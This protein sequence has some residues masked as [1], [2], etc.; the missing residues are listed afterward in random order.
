VNPR[1]RIYAAVGVAGV[2]VLGGGFLLLGRGGSQSSAAVH[3]IKPLHPVSQAAKRAA[4]MQTHKAK[5]AIKHARASVALAP[6]KVAKTEAA[7]DSMP[8]TLST[9]LRRNAV[10]VV[11]LVVPRATVDDLAYQEAKAGAREAGAGF[12]RISSGNADDVQALSTLIDSDADAGDRLLDAPA[13]LVFRR[14]QELYVRFN[15]Y[16]D[17]DTVAQAVENA[18]PVVHVQSSSG[19]LASSWVKTANEICT[20]LGMELSTKSLPTNRRD[21]V[22][23]AQEFVDTIRQGVDKI[24]HVKPPAGKKARVD[25]MLG[26]YDRLFAD[27]NAAL[28]AVR[29]GDV[30]TFQRLAAKVQREGAQGDAI[31]AELGATACSG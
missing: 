3:Q 21:L 26:A 25:A 27:A 31:A 4:R 14:P 9:A 29:R 2:I 8:T 24:R 19:P 20:K 11:S 17:A 30:A 5:P 16:I 12:V 23:Y 22:A 6:P 28:A 15:G 13:V 7:T 18:T 1:Y 10:V